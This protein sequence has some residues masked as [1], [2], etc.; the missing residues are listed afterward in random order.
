M[1]YAKGNETE[2]DSQSTLEET[3]QNFASATATDREAFA[4]LTNMNSQLHS[5][6]DQLTTANA[7][8]HR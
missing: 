2:T 3:V 4:S 5:Q 8:M 7:T 6:E 1:N